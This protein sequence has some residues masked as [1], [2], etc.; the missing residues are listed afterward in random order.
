MIKASFG[1]DDRRWRT[2]LYREL[3]GV[4]LLKGMDAGWDDFFSSIHM[5]I[6]TGRKMKF[7]RDKLWAVCVCLVRI[8]ALVCWFYMVFS[9][10]K[11]NEAPGEWSVFW[12][13]WACGVEG[14]L[15]SLQ[16]KNK[17]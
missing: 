12:I 6:I 16:V 5:R 15:Y 4:G 1:V 13:N 10:Y 8:G 17:G 7:W 2:K 9:L 3:H 14:G 11:R